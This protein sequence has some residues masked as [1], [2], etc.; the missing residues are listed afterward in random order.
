L[1]DACWASELF[2]SDSVEDPHDDFA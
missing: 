2:A 1:S